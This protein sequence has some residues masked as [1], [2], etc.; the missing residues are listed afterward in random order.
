MARKPR[1]AFAMASKF[2]HEDKPQSPDE[3]AG[4]RPPFCT[5]CGEEM[6]AMSVST[7]ITDKGV[8]GT[9]TYECKHCGGSTKV[10]RHSDNAGGLSIVPDFR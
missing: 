2:L 6:W 3:R 4:D 7:I 8:D 9:Y 10:H 1:K 5:Q